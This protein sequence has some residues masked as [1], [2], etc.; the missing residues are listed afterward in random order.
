VIGSIGSFDLVV[1][2]LQ[3]GA[4]DAVVRAM[5][6]VDRRDVFADEC[7][8]CD[9]YRPYLPAATTTLSPW[10]PTPRFEQRPVVHPTPR[11]EPRPVIHLE[12]RFELRGSHCPPPT[13][14]VQKPETE[15]PLQPP[16]KTVPWENPLPPA[17]PV[18]LASYRPD[19]T[20]RG[21]LLDAFI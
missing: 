14:V 7:R 17:Q 1:A 19:I 6:A 4:V 18:K 10:P 2:T 15:S 21:T 5:R 20:C 3:L 11:Y 9:G 12:P 13:I 16:W 8:R